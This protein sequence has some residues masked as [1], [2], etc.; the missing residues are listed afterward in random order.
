MNRD[1]VC[2][3][4]TSDQLERR[5]ETYQMNVQICDKMLVLA[6]QIDLMARFFASTTERWAQEPVEMAHTTT[7]PRVL[8]PFAHSS[9]RPLATPTSSTHTL[10]TDA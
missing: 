7:T 4:S 1:L 9:V 6:G 3:V 2:V 8:R 5:R 10:S